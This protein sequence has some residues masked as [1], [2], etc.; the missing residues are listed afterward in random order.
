MSYRVPPTTLVLTRHDRQRRLADY[1][2]GTIARRHLLRPVVSRASKRCTMTPQD[3]GEG[4]FDGYHTIG[5]WPFVDSRMSCTYPRFFERVV[6]FP[7]SNSWGGSEPYSC[8][9]L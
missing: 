7:L 2:D 3:R 5:A 8:R 6:P 1:E 9:V 4:T